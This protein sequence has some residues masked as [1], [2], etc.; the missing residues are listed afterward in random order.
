MGMDSRRSKDGDRD[1]F[2]T[3]SSSEG[4]VAP[5]SSPTSLK[6]DMSN[7]TNYGIETIYDDD[8]TGLGGQA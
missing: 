7:E 1:S 3:V 2:Q 6:A 5:S 8:T 4:Y